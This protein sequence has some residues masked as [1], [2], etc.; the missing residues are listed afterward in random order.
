[1]TYQPIN[2]YILVEAVYAET[3]DDEGY[4]VVKSID[5][6][7]DIRAKYY[8]TG[9]MNGI[10]LEFKELSLD[11]VGAV[12][13]IDADEHEEQCTIYDSYK[14]VAELDQGGEQIAWFE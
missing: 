6:I 8:G 14:Y 10:E 1:M 5:D 2:G 7:P 13:I 12:V 9:E 11:D 4:Y 3:G